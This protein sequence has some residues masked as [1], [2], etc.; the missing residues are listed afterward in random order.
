MTEIHDKYILSCRAAV[1]KREIVSNVYTKGL[2]R[3]TAEKFKFERHGM[4]PRDRE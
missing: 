3:P 1:Q 4:L 2:A